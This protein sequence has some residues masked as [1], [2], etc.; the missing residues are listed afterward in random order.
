[1]SDSYRDAMRMKQSRI[2]HSVLLVLESVLFGLFV[3][4]IGCDQVKKNRWASQ[5]SP[6]EKSPNKKNPTVGKSYC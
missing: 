1:M 4:A 5:K 3:I 2:L 6:S